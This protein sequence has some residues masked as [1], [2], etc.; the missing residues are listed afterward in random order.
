LYKVIAFSLAIT[1]HASILCASSLELDQIE[2]PYPNG[3][4]VLTTKDNGYG[5]GFIVGDALY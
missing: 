3:L 2:R 4:A 5:H 1:L